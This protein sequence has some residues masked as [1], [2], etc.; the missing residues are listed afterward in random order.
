[1]DTFPIL[2]KLH[3]RYGEGGLQVVGVLVNSGSVED[4]NGWVPHFAPEYRVWVYNDASL[5]DLI[6]SHLV[7]TYLFIDE[8]G[9][10]RKQLVGF[11]TEETVLANLDLIRSPGAF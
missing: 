1:M 2:Q 7:P 3:R 4:A 8:R 5:G 6:G 9:I 11:K 10:V